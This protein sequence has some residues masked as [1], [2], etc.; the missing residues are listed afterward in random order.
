MALTSHGAIAKPASQT[1][2][3]SF[4]T[5]SQ[6]EPRNGAAQRERRTGRQGKSRHARGQDGTPP[7]RHRGRPSVGVAARRNGQYA[8]PN[9][10]HG[11]GGRVGATGRGHGGRHAGSALRRRGAHAD[12]CL[13]RGVQHDWASA[14]ALLRSPSTASWRF[15]TRGSAGHDDE[16]TPGEDRRVRC[17]PERAPSRG[18]DRPARLT[19]GRRDDRVLRAA[20]PPLGSTV[21]VLDRDDAQVGTARQ[22]AGPRSPTSHGRACEPSLP[23]PVGTGRAS[24]CVG[25]DGSDAADRGR[26]R[27]NRWRRPG[28][29]GVLPFPIDT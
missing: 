25:L 7:T 28:R 3:I 4:F 13:R 2:A 26:A 15:A 21:R 16:V 27:G 8:P 22:M 1:R 14:A 18:P 29:V 19:L 10:T 23:A 11:L 12:Q 6:R 5:P 17:S 20:R 24:Q 9:A